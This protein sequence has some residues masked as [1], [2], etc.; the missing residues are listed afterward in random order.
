MEKILV[1]LLVVSAVSGLKYFPNHLPLSD[2]LVNY[3]NN[4]AQ[5]TWKAG[6]NF[7]GRGMS[8]AGLKR[9]C[10]VI[11]EPNNMKL[12]YREPHYITDFNDIP[13]EFDSRKQWPNCSSIGY[14]Y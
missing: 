8:V 1:A 3:I 5:T 7:E 12:P 4:E 9:M 10:G 13:E 11:P 2:E 14:E 6:K